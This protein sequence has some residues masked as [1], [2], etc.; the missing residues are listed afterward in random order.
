MYELKE[1]FDSLSFI[2]GKV[3]IINIEEN[4]FSNGIHKGY[5]YL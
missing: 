3:K 1:P 5:T 4:K 2:H